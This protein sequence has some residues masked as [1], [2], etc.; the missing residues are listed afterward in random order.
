MCISDV[1]LQP[2]NKDPP[3]SSTLDSFNSSLPFQGLLYFQIQIWL[4]WLTLL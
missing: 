1:E 3:H 4:D 2:E